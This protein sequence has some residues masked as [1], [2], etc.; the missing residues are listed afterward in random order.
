MLS[1]L[2]SDSGEEDSTESFLQESIPTPTQ[3]VRL[4]QRR[5]SVARPFYFSA[6]VIRP[7]YRQ[8]RASSAILDLPTVSLLLVL[9]WH[10]RFFYL[11]VGVHLTEWNVPLFCRNVLKKLHWIYT[12]KLKCGAPHKCNFECNLGTSG[13][14]LTKKGWQVWQ[15]CE[16]SRFFMRSVPLKNV[17]MLARLQFV[18]NFYCKFVS[19]NCIAN[20]IFLIS[21]FLVIYTP[22]SPFSGYHRSGWESCPSLG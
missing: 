6:R 4:E 11:I 18:H 17:S 13:R 16:R 1:C 21:Y 5:V 2:V 15:I 3:A 22:N 20:L 7:T 8:V 12:R 9:A 19:T 14:F 10:S